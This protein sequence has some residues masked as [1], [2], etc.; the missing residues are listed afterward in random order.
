MAATGPGITIIGSG[1]AGL[2][3]AI[4][5]KDAGY[6]DFVILE[7][8]D[9]LGGTWR[10]NTYPGCACDVPVAPVLLLVRAQPGLVAPLRAAAGDLGLPASA[11][12]TSTALRRHIR[13]GTRGRAR[14]RAT[15]R[16]GRWRVEH[17]RRRR[18]TARAR[19]LRRRRAARARRSR[20]SRASSAFEGTTFHSAALGPRR[21]TSTGKRV[22]VIGTGASAI[23]FVPQIAPNVRAADRVPAH[24]AVDPC[25]KPDLGYHAGASSALFARCPWPQRPCARR[26]LLAAGDQGARLHRR[27]AADEGAPSGWRARTCGARS[28]DPGAARAG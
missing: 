28:P 20:T 26:D 21:T 23:Q 14:W 10:D 3:M 25:R 22:A 7:K 27:P 6:H 17:G 16:A 15:R 8:A 9:D 4:R 12:P 2:G 18:L 1:F 5:L 13:F 19:G 11:A 24:A